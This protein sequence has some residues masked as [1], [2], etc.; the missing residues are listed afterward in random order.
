[1]EGSSM[2][3]QPKFQ[4]LWSLDNEVAAGNASTQN[5]EADAR[6]LLSG[7]QGHR[8]M[9]SPGMD[10]TCAAEDNEDEQD[11]LSDSGSTLDSPRGGKKGG[12]GRM[13][14]S[15]T[16]NE[17]T[18]FPRKKAGQD[19]LG[20]NRP[21][22]I[23]TREV[24][25]TYFDM[26]QQLVC[27]KLGICATVIK[28]VCRQLGIDKWP[29]KGNKIDLRKRGLGPASRKDFLDEVPGTPP[30]GSSSSTCLSNDESSSERKEETMRYLALNQKV[31]AAKSFTRAVT[32]ETPE[33]KPAAP[34]QQGA[35]P[36]LEN[37]NQVAQQPAR[38][39]LINTMPPA[40]ADIKPTVGTPKAKF[41]QF[42]TDIYVA[43]VPVRGAS[44]PLVRIKEDVD[45][46]FVR[47]EAAHQPAAGPAQDGVV[48]MGGHVAR[49]TMVRHAEGAQT[50]LPAHSLAM[51]AA[52]TQG[53]ETVEQYGNE[54]C[55][56]GW[57]VAPEPAR[58]FGKMQD[59]ED[60]LSPFY[61]HGPQPGWG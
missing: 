35:A 13:R 21:P 12:G 61:R 14:M 11:A 15:G 54:G 17:V 37:H 42:S 27:K 51:E 44:H 26:P 55:D 47:Q 40:R 41:G 53:E 60:I 50:Q 10:Y 25:E 5:R 1:M 46:D 28:K 23:I 45:A 32:S 33:Y 52:E 58:V 31:A 43:G 49:P 39:E 6:Q 36:V 57:L 18:I 59:D 22:I 16:S 7:Q 19:K 29:Y 56:L 24:L 20:S 38:P 30:P 9:C 2:A 4:N 3:D 48:M 8:S 34:Q